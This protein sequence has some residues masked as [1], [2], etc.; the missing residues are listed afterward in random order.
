MVEIAKNFLLVMGVAA[1]PIVFW[2]GFLEIARRSSDR[3]H[4]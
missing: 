3:D 1:V 4:T 2:Y